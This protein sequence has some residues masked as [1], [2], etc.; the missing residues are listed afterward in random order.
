MWELVPLSFMVDRIVNIRQG[1]SALVN[2]LYPRVRILAASV[3]TR[4]EKLFNIRVKDIIHPDYQMT[5]NSETDQVDES[6]FSY[7]RVVWEPNAAD[8]APIINTRPLLRDISS[9]A[10]LTSLIVT[11]LK[12]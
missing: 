6:Q 10:D 12:G 2:F 9:I 11:K 4:D 3:T 1:V 7:D 5:A 8:I